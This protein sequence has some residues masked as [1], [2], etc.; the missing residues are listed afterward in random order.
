MANQSDQ[1]W[2]DISAVLE[3]AT[4]AKGF[5]PE[6]E[7]MA[8]SRAAQHAASAG[9]EPLLE[10]GSYCGKSTLYL[11]AGVLAAALISA[12]PPN[13]LYSL[14][15][16]R[17][18]EELQA[19]WEHHDPTLVD[20]DTGLIETLPHWRANIRSAGVEDL[21][22]GLIGDSPRIAAS[23]TT[24]LGLLFI[25]GGHGAG[26][27][28]ADYNGWAPR[29]VRG[30]LLCIHDVFESPEAGGRPPY[31]IYRRTVGGGAFREMAGASVGS[32]R[33]LERV[34]PGR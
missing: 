3:H 25:D 13:V 9:P 23:W 33:V 11:A 6:P 8:L 20:G 24:P 34:A 7:G 26:P 27:A 4:R 22:V 16:H 14:D 31:E 29:V 18:S 5:M 32:M 15:H 19:G 17:G 21:V 2:A 1:R 10:V 30:G 28:W 12:R